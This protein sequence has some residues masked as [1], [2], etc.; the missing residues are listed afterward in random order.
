MR[1]VSVTPS[2]ADSVLVSAPADCAGF[3]MSSGLTSPWMIWCV[4]SRPMVAM[5]PATAKSSGLNLAQASAGDYAVRASSLE[6]ARLKHADT[7]NV[8]L[9]TIPWAHA[10]REGTST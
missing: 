8:P 3:G 7:L 4:P 1:P 9:W 10:H 6:A 5:Q 2:P